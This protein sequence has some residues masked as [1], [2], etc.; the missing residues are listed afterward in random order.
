LQQALQH[1]VMRVATLVAIAMACKCQ[2]GFAKP[3]CNS[4]YHGAASAVKVDPGTVKSVSVMCA[5]QPARWRTPLRP[6]AIT[7]RNAEALP[8]ATS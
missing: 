5:I 4:Q 3:L 6:A 8:L 2:P 7:V 1:H